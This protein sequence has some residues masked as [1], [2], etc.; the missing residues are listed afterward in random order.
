MQWESSSE[1]TTNA[2][3]TLIK[4][5]LQKNLSKNVIQI[6][7]SGAKTQDIVDLVIH[8]KSSTDQADFGNRRKKIKLDISKE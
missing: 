5:A 3:L 8:A 7:F 2:T 4:F 6:L 1:I